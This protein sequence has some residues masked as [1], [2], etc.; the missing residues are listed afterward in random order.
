MRHPAPHYLGK[1]ATSKLL[2]DAA[3]LIIEAAGEIGPHF[4]ET[5]ERFARMY[6]D[7][8]FAGYFTDCPDMKFFPA[9]YKG[10]VTLTP[11][12]IFSMCPHHIVLWFG[13]VHI[14]YVPSKRMAGLSKFVRVARWCAS[15]MICQEDYTTLL[16]DTLVEKLHPQGV[17]V[18][19]KM[20]HMC[21]GCRGVKAPEVMTITDAVRGVY[22]RTLNPRDEAMRLMCL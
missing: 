6:M 16:A 3:H 7:E 8:L 20:R 10:M 5:P 1:Y 11:I 17:M 22:R 21:M 18:V 14:S 19:V 9:K 15:R 4:K 2:R 13:T 12:N